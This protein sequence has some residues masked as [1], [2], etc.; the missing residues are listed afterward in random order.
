[1][2]GRQ[3]PTKRMFQKIFEKW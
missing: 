3:Q 2:T 1:M